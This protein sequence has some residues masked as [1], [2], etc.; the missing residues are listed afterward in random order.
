[1]R[2]ITVNIL[3]GNEITTNALEL[4]LGGDKEAMAAVFSGQKLIR[5]IKPNH[6]RI[7]LTT[8]SGRDYSFVGYSD[9]PKIENYKCDFDYLIA[10]NAWGTI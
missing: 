2:N 5:R 6:V 9:Y 8:D 3:S 10:L 1:M 4:A 7:D